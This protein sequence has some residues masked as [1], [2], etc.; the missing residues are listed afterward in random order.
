MLAEEQATEL[1][2]LVVW[3][4]PSEAKKPAGRLRVRSLFKTD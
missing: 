3:S 4:T 1:P 2:E